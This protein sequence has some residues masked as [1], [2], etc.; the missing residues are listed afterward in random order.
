MWRTLTKKRISMN[1]PG[2]RGLQSDSR[3]VCPGDLFIAIS[4]TP[5]ERLRYIQEATERGAVAV[6]AEPEICALVEES[7]QVPLIPFCDLQKSTG[8]I[9]AH[10]FGQ[11]SLEYPV[12]GVTGTSGK[13]SIAYFILQIMAACKKKYAMIGTLGSGFLGGLQEIQNTTPGAIVLQKLLADFAQKKAD[14]VVMEVSSHALHQERVAG[15]QF[16]TAIFSNLTRDHLD[17]HGT[18]ESYWAEKQRLFLEYKPRYAIVNCDNDYG[19]ELSKKLVDQQQDIIGFSIDS[20]VPFESLQV[21]MVIAQDVRLQQNG[22]NAW[23]QSP[24]GEGALHSPLL[25]RFTL[26]NLLAAMSAVCLQGIPL[27]Q[28]LSVIPEVNTAEGRMMLF[29][30]T[31]RLPLVVV[32]YAHKPEAVEQVLT[33]LKEQ[34]QGGLLWCILGCGG[35]R[36]RGK[37]PLMAAL[38]ERFSDRFVITSDNPRTETLNQIVA[39]MLTGLQ[40]PNAVSVQLDRKLAIQQTILTAAPNDIVAVLGKGHEAYQIIGNTAFPFSD[41]EEV[42]IALKKREV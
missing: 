23:I 21:P 38:A 42:Q 9:A 11:P 7:V 29:G 6:L 3:Q 13:T 1:E 16:H 39:D 35:E 25:G 17:Y 30:N 24:W 5:N 34:C 40:N 32:D 8:F 37:R 22:I 28:V 12:I 41:S 20:G 18:M 14:G 4:G 26:S 2:I 19:R 31:P 33:F 10:F 36:D 15:T 27:S